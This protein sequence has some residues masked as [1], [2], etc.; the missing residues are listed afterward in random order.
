M[1][2]T[3]KSGE[4]LWSNRGH[5]VCDLKGFAVVLDQDMDIELDEDVAE[6]TIAAIKAV[7][8]FRGCDPDTGLPLPKPEEVVN[9]V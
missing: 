3:L 5:H 8:E 6:V 1:I 9:G 7:R 2:V 4:Y